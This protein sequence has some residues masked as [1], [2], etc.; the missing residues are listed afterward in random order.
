MPDAAS[1]NKPFQN[2]A[3]AGTLVTSI[4]PAIA[5]MIT[6]ARN[7]VSIMTSLRGLTPWAFVAAMA[8]GVG[9]VWD[10]S[11]AAFS[12]A[13]NRGLSDA[14]MKLSRI[15]PKCFSVSAITSPIVA[16]MQTA[17]A[18]GEIV[19][20][21]LCGDAPDEIMPASD[22]IQQTSSGMVQVS[23]STTVQ[24][25]RQHSKA[26]CAANIGQDCVN[27]PTPSRS[28]SM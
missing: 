10:R 5:S 23:I 11:A 7:A 1:S 6:G 24:T 9:R 2:A 28:S 16:P 25:S 4:A 18:A 17:P 22:T 8:C 12:S 19:G 14:S 26:A 15:R 3:I 21:K 13:A 20:M 27:G